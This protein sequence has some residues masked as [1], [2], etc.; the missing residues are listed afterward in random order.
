[1]CIVLVFPYWLFFFEELLLEELLIIL[2]VLADRRQGLGGG[3]SHFSMYY[4]I[5]RHIGI[6]VFVILEL[7]RFL[8]LIKLFSLS[9]LRSLF[10]RVMIVFNAMLEPYFHILHSSVKVTQLPNFLLFPFNVS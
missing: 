7:L 1:M 5:N 2:F 3:R 4:L 10:V 9:N 6:L 8:L